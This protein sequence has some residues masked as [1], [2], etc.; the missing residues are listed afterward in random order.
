VP[1]PGWFLAFA[2]LAAPDEAR[3]RGEV[4]ADGV[5]ALVLEAPP[6]L[7]FVL[8]TSLYPGEFRLP[9]GTA[10]ALTLNQPAANTALRGAI[11]AS[12]RWTHRLE[13]F[14]DVAGSQTLFFQG[15]L[16]EEGSADRARAVTRALALH[17]GR[18]PAFEDL[19]EWA[20]RRRVRTLAAWGAAAALALAALAVRGI[21]AAL[22][23]FAIVALAGAAGWAIVQSAPRAWAALRGLPLSLDEAE[24][25]SLG[26]DHRPAL[27]AARALVPAG[28]PLL[29]APG[30]EVPTI[31]FEHLQ[32]VLLPARLHAGDPAAFARA[33][34]DGTG[35]VLARGEASPGPLVVRAS[36]EL[37]GGYRLLQ[38]GAR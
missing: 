24:T 11:P 16:Y 27:A 18:P 8:V 36:R 10:L 31:S 5:P 28:A 29:L 12:G 9:D 1:I 26:R 21:A 14:G 4:G 7:L 19:E 34:G 35:W 6:G 37:P 30:V 2:L 33:L 20:R 22:R 38:V 15:V 23:R 25:R 3:L 13:D 17:A 32:Y